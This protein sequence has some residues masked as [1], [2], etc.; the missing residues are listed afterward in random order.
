MKIVDKTPF[1]KDGELSLMDRGKAIMQFGIGWF[2]EIDAQKTVIAVMERLLDK[3][4]TILRNVTPPGLDTTIPIILIGQTGVYVMCVTSLTGMYR[5]KGDQ[6]GTISGNEFKPGKPNLL[7][8]TERMARAVQ[9]FLQRQGYADLPSVEAI[10]LCSDPSIHVDS[11]RPIVRIVMRD[12]LERFTVSITQAR[13]VLSPE[14]VYDVVNCILNPSASPTPPASPEGS[15]VEAV[16][17]SEKQEEDPYASTYALLGSQPAP[18]TTEEAI[19]PARFTQAPPI[20]SRPIG[21][22][23]RP[24]KR[25]LTGKQW[26][27]LIGMFAIWCLL[28]GA[29]A[30]FLVFYSN[31]L[32]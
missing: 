21:Q 14:S 5:A 9:M 25:G 16:V 24:R 32:H 3:N 6:W 31:L 19:P 29:A 28:A 20:R 18:V 10:L 12:A 8:R 15:A 22:R 26:T 7:T 2:K 13:V 27:L 17:P 4:Y 11:L 23:V 1:Y 30:I